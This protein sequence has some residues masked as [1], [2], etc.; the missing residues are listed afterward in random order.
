MNV[1]YF[2][3]FYSFFFLQALLSLQSLQM[4]HLQTIGQLK[5]LQSLE[6]GNCDH[7]EPD[8]LFSSIQTFTHLK[9][10]RLERGKFNDSIG[11][12]CNLNKLQTLEL[13]DFEMVQGFGTGL[14]QLQKLRKFLLIPIYKDEV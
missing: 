2:K 12:L 10:L 5:T 11:E 1:Q 8:S 13:I 4:E 3:T 7:I 9:Y 14:V 6:L